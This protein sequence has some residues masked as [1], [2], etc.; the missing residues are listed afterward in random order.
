MNLYQFI[1]LLVQSLVSLGWPIA[2]VVAFWLFHKEIRSMLPRM[3]FKYKDV[4][5]TFRLDEAEKIVKALPAPAADPVPVPETRE[6]KDK[7]QKIAEL[8]PRAAILELRNELEASVVLFG[9]HVGLNFANPRKTLTY[10]IRVLRGENFIDAQ[11]SAL[12]DD[13]R[14]IGNTAAHDDEK[15]I[16]RDDAF[17]YKSLVETVIARFRSIEAGQIKPER[18]TEGAP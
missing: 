1:A 2:F 8:S 7:F 6:E 18:P 5:V 14:V 10:M 15:S 9:L 17:R 12:L 16:T 11:T 13:L 3:R 4:D